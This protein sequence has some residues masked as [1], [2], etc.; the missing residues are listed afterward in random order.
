MQLAAQRRHCSE[1]A[2]AYRTLLGD[3]AESR[4]VDR[5][6][7]DTLHFL[8]KLAVPAPQ[9]IASLAI[10]GHVGAGKTWLARCFITAPDDTNHMLEELRS[11]D[12]EDT[13]QATWIGPELPVN[14]GNARHLRCGGESLLDLGRPYVVCDSPGFNH[15]RGD[16]RDIANE[17]LVEAQIKVFVTSYESLRDG[18]AEALVGFC[19]GAIIVPVIRLPTNDEDFRDPSAETRATVERAVMKWI[20][21]A[22]ASTFTGPVFVPNECRLG[23]E[24][25]VRAVQERLRC[26]LTPLLRN[27]P[28]IEMSVVAQADRRV[29]RADE[30]ALQHVEG[31]LAKAW[32][33]LERLDEATRRM[34]DDALRELVGDDAPLEAVIRQELRKAL[35]NGTS[36]GF[37]PYKPFL[38]T[39]AL[40]AGAWDRLLFLT[41]GS[42]PSLAMTAFQVGKNIKE[43]VQF[44]RRF[45]LRLAKRIEASLADRL[46]PD[47]RLLATATAA[48]GSDGLNRPVS[49]PGVRVHGV[50]E[51]QECSRAIFGKVVATYRPSW[52]LI[53]GCGL[54]ALVSFLLLIMSPVLAVF[55]VYVRSCIEAATHGFATLDFLLPTASMLLGAAAISSVPS[56][57]LA[58]VAMLLACR[59][60]RVR[61]AA[62]SARAA[63]ASEVSERLADQRLRFD[64]LDPHI[65]ALRQVLAVRQRVA[66]TK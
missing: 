61:S 4:A 31:I 8:D 66:S 57:V 58:W 36:D 2:A 63:H 46:Q 44:A 51:L 25:A 47:L 59:H 16:C 28:G 54:A 41:T 38:R 33:S 34:S 17:A 32:P 7:G 30:A 6:Y 62:V 49:Q 65:S 40:T 50:E 37:F 10:V 45:R 12:H 13:Q 1:M 35:I 53:N 29:L 39:L 9:A 55:S 21:A 64:V 11:G 24:E 23:H 20:R 5:I 27:T 42:L 15:K 60:S 26:V 43:G 18:V 52:M 56:I 48:V 22:P 3:S 14:A 19:E